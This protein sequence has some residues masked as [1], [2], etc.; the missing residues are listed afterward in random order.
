MVAEAVNGEFHLLYLLR[1]LYGN[2]LGV[3]DSVIVL[4][5]VVLLRI[6]AMQ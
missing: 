3:L 5:R 4:C 1:L 6:G 2:A